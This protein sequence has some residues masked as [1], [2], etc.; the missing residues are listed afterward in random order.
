[1]E[2]DLSY[3]LKDIATYIG[4]IPCLLA[5]IRIN[6][7]FREHRLLSILVWGSTAIGLIAQL[8]VS[9]FRVPNLFLLHIYVVFD[10]ILLTLLFR[11]VLRR[12]IMKMLLIA[13]PIFA[14]INSVLLAHLNSM[15]LINRSIS[16][17]IIMGYALTYF[18]QT[19][20]DMKVEQIEKEPLLW[21]SIAALFYN[22]AS[23][24]IFLFGKDLDL[25][26]ELWLTY[27]GLHAIFTI[28]MYS[29]YTIA[30]W[31]NPK[32]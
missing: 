32:R 8:L 6:S 15:N 5:F 17:F 24:F 21:I 22:A 31:V 20:K 10:F 27:F 25:H 7:P 16:S 18:T 12:P 28:L 14:I 13:F 11:P 4:L 1:M 3:L 2:K 29:L 30:L 26:H 9:V 23:F 19:L